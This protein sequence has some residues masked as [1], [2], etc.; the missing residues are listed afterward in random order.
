MSDPKIDLLS[1]WD[2]VFEMIQE[3]MVLEGKPYSDHNP[4]AKAL[5]SETGSTESA[6][7]TGDLRD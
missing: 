4:Y 7:Q 3:K 2:E 5:T 1:L 6:D